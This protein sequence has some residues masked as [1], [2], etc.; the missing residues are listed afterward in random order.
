MAST[1]ASRP[2]RPAWRL[3]RGVPRG[4]PWCLRGMPHHVCFCC[5]FTWPW[6]CLEASDA[7]LEASEACLEA[8]AAWIGGWPHI[9]R[10]SIFPA[11]CIAVR[12]CSRPASSLHRLCF[13]AIYIASSHAC[14]CLFVCLHVCLSFSLFFLPMPLCFYVCM[15][16]CLQSLSG[17]P[18]SCHPLAREQKPMQANENATF[19]M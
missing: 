3:P 15:Y 17:L 16:A 2:P 11:I 8:S 10:V 19:T 7:C 6:A 18:V 12:L 9:A 4:L 13:V 5:N 14:V 1:P